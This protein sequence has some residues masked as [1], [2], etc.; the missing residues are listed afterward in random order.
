MFTT[1]SLDYALFSC[2]SATTKYW[3]V[4]SHSCISVLYQWQC[5]AR[6]LHFHC[7]QRY[8]FTSNSNLKESDIEKYSC[9][10]TAVIDPSVS[11]PKS[12][13]KCNSGAQFYVTPGT[14]SSRRWH[15]AGKNPQ[16]GWRYISVLT[17]VT[18][19]SG[20]RTAHHACNHW[21]FFLL[22]VHF[23][24]NTPTLGKQSSA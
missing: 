13:V 12:P 19:A 24:I 9:W 15:L 21:L 10:V 23:P 20:Q 6:H 8:P 16:K 22:W 1:V 4:C 14:S 7:Y 5:G 17:C 11:H 18:T 3:L 2:S